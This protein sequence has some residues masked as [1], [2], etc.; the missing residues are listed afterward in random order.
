M[1]S[2]FATDLPRIMIAG[3]DSNS[4]TI[5][6]D[7][8]PFTQVLNSISNSLLNQGYDVKD[9][10]A[11]STD[12]HTHGKTR[13]NQSELLKVAK[14][15]GIDIVVIFSIYPNK[16][17]DQNTVRIMPRVEGRLVSVYDG[18]RLGNIDLKSQISKPIAK[19]Y[20]RN[21]ELEALTDIS[22][23]LGQEIGEI[24][25]ER[26]NGYVDAEGGHL[27]EWV[28]TFDGFNN[29]EIMD[30][31]DAI[32]TFPGY[33]SHRIKSNSQNSER[34]AEFFYRSSIDSADLKRDLVRVFKKL[35]LKSSIYTSGLQ[36]RAVRKRGMMRN[37]VK[38]QNS[39]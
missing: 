17:V 36:F 27:Q 13:R 21:E 35:N 3:D 32:K 29:Y 25:A 20:S 14:D 12:S 5:A 8:R 34:H 19:P 2:A 7:S 26:I 15:L 30:I 39:W 33:D 28:M 31:E 38:Q 9:E 11:L 22:A 6:R 23:I 4:G 10:V 37:R 18:S 16:K 1:N 24:L